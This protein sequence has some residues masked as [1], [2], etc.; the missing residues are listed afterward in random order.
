MGASIGG[1]DS[2]RS[3]LACCTR[4]AACSGSGNRRR[5]KHGLRLAT[6]GSS[7][8]LPAPGR[9]FLP[10]Q[11]LR[12]WQKNRKGNA[13]VLV[14]VPTI[15]LRDQWARELQHHGQYHGRQLQFLGGGEDASSTAHLIVEPGAHLLCVQRVTET[16]QGS[17]FGYLRRPV[18]LAHASMSGRY[19]M[20]APRRRATGPGKSLYLRYPA[21]PV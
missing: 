5:W 19:Q 2:V 4:L 18:A 20:N 13:R 16:G 17:S 7:A 9:R 6:G 1:Q 10:S 3:C 11:R 21:Y 12:K 14:V 15:A 8:L